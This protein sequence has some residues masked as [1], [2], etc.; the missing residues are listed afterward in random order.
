VMRVM[1][2]VVV[3]AGASGLR[4]QRHGSQGTDA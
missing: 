4:R 1:V 3:V 2:R